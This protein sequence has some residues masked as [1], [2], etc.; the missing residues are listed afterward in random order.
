MKKYLL[1]LLILVGLGWN[2]ARLFFRPDSPAPVVASKPVV[3]P[4][5]PRV[6]APALPPSS[7]ATVAPAPAP[8]TMQLVRSSGAN[9]SLKIDLN[10][11]L[12]PDNRYHDDMVGVSAHVPPGWKVRE[13]ARWGDGYRENT[14]W[15]QPDGATTA[16]PSMYYR[17]YRD[18][19]AADRYGN[20][21]ALMRTMAQKKEESR[22][23]GGFADYKNVPESFAFT[24]INGNPSL[25]YFAT[26]TQG[27]DVK[28]EYFIRILGPTGYVMFFTTGRLE[29]VKAA[30]PQLQKMAGSVKVR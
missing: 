13:A 26:Y 4:I 6:Q 30:M 11:V 21:E 15:M 8:I 28:T 27:N 14:M 25:S 18:N 29:D 2:G 12:D 3:T 16:N 19:E 20:V 22:T 9:A 1:L 23:G 24:E 7:P 10:L 5:T 17:A